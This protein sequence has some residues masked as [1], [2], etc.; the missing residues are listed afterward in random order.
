M[1]DAGLDE[2]NDAELTMIWRAVGCVMEYEARLDPFMFSEVVVNAGNTL[3]LLG[4]FV[5]TYLSY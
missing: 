5:N 3:A 2:L 4:I 1:N